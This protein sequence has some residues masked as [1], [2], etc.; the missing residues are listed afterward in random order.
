MIYLLAEIEHVLFENK[1]QVILTKRG[2]GFGRGLG[3]PPCSQGG[4]VCVHTVFH[5]AIGVHGLQ[6][7]I[8]QGR[9]GSEEKK[10]R[11]RIS[12]KQPESRENV[13]LKK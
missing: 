2:G 13:T 9:I 12:Q 10:K 4:G 5:Q 11:K 1:G 3:L 8:V 6:I 7:G